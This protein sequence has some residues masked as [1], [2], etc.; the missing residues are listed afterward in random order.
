MQPLKDRS[1]FQETRSLP[2]KCMERTRIR[3]TPKIAEGPTISNNIQTGKNRQQ[4]GEK[5]AK[6]RK[7]NQNIFKGGLRPSE[8]QNAL[9]C[10]NFFILL[11][12][13]S[14]S[15]FRRHIDKSRVMPEEGGVVHSQNKHLAEAK[16]RGIHFGNALPSVKHSRI[17]FS[18]FN[19]EI[20][21]ISQ[22]RNK[23]RDMVF[24]K[25]KYLLKRAFFFLK[26]P[27]ISSVQIPLD[28]R[29]SMYTKTFLQVL[30]INRRWPLK[31]AI[32]APHSTPHLAQGNT[33]LNWYLHD[34]EWGLRGWWF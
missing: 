5:P 34:L 23:K 33:E 18:F 2:A 31:L 29:P 15:E 14:D 19:Y 3:S 8:C 11:S 30:Y 10:D 16:P 13:I 26:C 20:Q 6:W 22:E 9:S 28:N 17:S 7:S 21:Q 1:N 25:M 32:L 24:W 4:T 12:C 27:I